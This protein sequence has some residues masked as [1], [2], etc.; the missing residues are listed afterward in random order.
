[1]LVRRAATLARLF[2][3]VVA[4]GVC[5]R[6]LLYRNDSCWGCST[7]PS[8]VQASVVVM[9][10]SPKRRP[11]FDQILRAYAA[12]PY[13]ASVTLLWNNAREDPPAVPV[14]D[15]A[16]KI[17]VVR[18]KK[19]S[20][21]NRYLTEQVTTDAVLTIDDD[22]VMD[23]ELLHEMLRVWERN[24]DRVVG[25]DRRY[26][27][28]LDGQY[29]FHSSAVVGAYHVVAGKTMMFHRRFMALYKGYT[30]MH[31]SVDS[32]ECRGCDDIAF[33]AF[34]SSATGRGPLAVLAHP[35]QRRELP[36]PEGVSDPQSGDDDEAWRARRTVCGHWLR[37]NF[38][39]WPRLATEVPD[40]A[41]G[42]VRGFIYC[43]LCAFA[44][45][46]ARRDRKRS[47]QAQS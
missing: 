14:V 9:G 5:C 45:V 11:G 3:A 29:Y 41:M 6:V 38:G 15:G 23:D 42:R 26:F 43:C 36:S 19:N 22:V 33:C 24:S 7:G 47:V 34:V 37:N 40:V 8:S 1:M 21:N 32:G 35:G 30:E 39:T 27:G 12:S 13:V 25:L 2:L 20:L 17:T 10:Y 16:S 4:A 44:A 18:S 46:L 31:A 28:V